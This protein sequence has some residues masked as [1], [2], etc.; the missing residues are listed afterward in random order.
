MLTALSSTRHSRAGSFL[1]RMARS[2][3]QRV[4][5]AREKQSEGALLRRALST[6]P[7]PPLN[8]SEFDVIAELKLRS[9]AAGELTD[10][11]SLIHI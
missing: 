11:L 8:L 3:R 4:S 7:P 1:D 6:P 10:E 9:P 2:S 5:E